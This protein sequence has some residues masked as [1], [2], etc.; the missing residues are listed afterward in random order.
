MVLDVTKPDEQEDWSAE[1]L[2][3][4][5]KV[6]SSYVRRLC[7][8]RVLRCRKFAGSWLI[9]YQEGW[10]WL[11]ECAEKSKATPEETTLTTEA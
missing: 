2:S 7:R 4:A 8:K 9:P 3:Q 11:S 1:T 5:A 10:R 6:S